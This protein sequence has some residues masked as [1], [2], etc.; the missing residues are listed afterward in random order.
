[1]TLDDDYSMGDVFN[2]MKKAK[3]EKRAQNRETSPEI[4]RRAGVAFAEFNMGAHLVVKHGDGAITVDFWPGT[5]K[6]IVRGGRKGRGVFNLLR[7]LRVQIPYA[8]SC[9]SPGDANG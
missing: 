3:Q 1:M 2:A 9:S 7:L 4:L 5:G 8:T 6:W